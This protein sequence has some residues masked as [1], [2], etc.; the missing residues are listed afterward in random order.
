MTADTIVNLAVACISLEEFEKGKEFLDRA[1]RIQ[2]KH[3]GDDHIVT[4]ITYR[5]LGMVYRL[6]KDL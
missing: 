3:Y 2:N 1:L 6:M 5:N 4:A